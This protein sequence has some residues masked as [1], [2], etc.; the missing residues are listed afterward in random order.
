VVSVLTL[1]TASAEEAAVSDL[2]K[3]AIKALYLAQQALQANS[4]DEAIRVLSEYMG[5]ATAEIPLPAF[6]MLG[7]AYYQKK[8]VTNAQRIFQRGHEAF[9][10]DADMLLNLAVLTYEL[11]NHEEESARLF[12]KLYVLKGKSDPK[13][14]YQASS[15]YFYAKRLTEAK[16]VLTQL[17]TS[18]VEPELRWYDDIIALCIELKQP[19]EAERWARE[20]LQRQPGQARYWRLLA[21][22]HLDREE[23]REAAGALEVAHRLEGAKEGEWL[24]LSE[25]YLYLN[26][27]LMAIRCME[28][29]YPRKMPASQK[30]KV[31][32]TYARTLR[33]DEALTSI[34]EALQGNPSPDLFFEKGRLL[35]DAM[36]FEE[37]I[38]AL[39]QC[40][41]LDPQYG[42]AYVLA[43][44]AAWNMKQWER[45]RSAFAR[46][47][48]L[49]KFRDQAN[50]A[51]AV[52]DDLMATL[53]EKQD[54]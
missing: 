52:L 49:P 7:H 27:P 24:E 1:A 20:T 11:G 42:Q 43:G 28:Y 47:S 29:A 31:A 54:F 16:R 17:L 34:E 23:Y 8:D 3:E 10:Q 40:A 35:Y 15:L 12:E 41:R 26:A 25:L 18:G 9:P 46:A 39:E 38:S 48:V 4:Q 19:A 44:F 45:A 33:L 50:D 51:V 2:P 22:V 14:L 37:A 21:Q 30:A 32:A 6:Q 13:L 53:A 36:R 5:S